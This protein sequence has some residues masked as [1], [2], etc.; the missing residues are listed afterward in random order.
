[1]PDARETPQPIKAPLTPGIG[2]GTLKAVVHAREVEYTSE[3][4][5]SAHAR[6]SKTLWPR[7]GD[8]EVIDDEVAFGEVAM[9]AARRT[10][11]RI[12]LSS[13]AGDLLRWAPITRVSVTMSLEQTLS[14]YHAMR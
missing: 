5:D 12:I 7:L 8:E 4:A 2:D 9:D 1:M 3:Q 11:R 10:R 14:S 6:V 13:V